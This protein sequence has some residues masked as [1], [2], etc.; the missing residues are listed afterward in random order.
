ML[1]GEAVSQGNFRNAAQGQE[2][3]Q[4]QQA[5]NNTNSAAQA[6]FGQGL[7]SAQFGNQA[8]SQAIQEADYFKNQPLN[9]LNALRSGNQVMMPQFGNVSGGSQIAPAPIY[10]ASSDQY[11]AAMQQYQ[12][13][14]A[15]QSAM[16]GGVAGIGG[17]ALMGSDRRLKKGIK[18]LGRLAD[19]LGLYAYSYRWNNKRRIGVMADEVAVLRPYALG[20][21]INGFG[22]VNY[23]AL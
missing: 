12:A 13:K 21:T 15:Q 4:N 10:Q 19:G 18:L 22:S 8:R 6:N 3:E 16:M 17:A 2:F 20:P 23:G 11:S 7:A 9:M 1:L 5:L 14:L